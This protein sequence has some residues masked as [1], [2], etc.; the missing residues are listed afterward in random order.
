MKKQ[1]IAKDFYKALI[2]ANP[3]SW[4]KVIVRFEPDKKSQ[5]LFKE[6]LK[7]NPFKINKDYLCLGEIKNM[8]E[9]FIYVDTT[10]KVF[11]GYHNDFFR[12]LTEDD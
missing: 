3:D 8:P 1:I 9:H 7:S 12:I 10:G 6:E 5:K 4:D 2:R 11:W